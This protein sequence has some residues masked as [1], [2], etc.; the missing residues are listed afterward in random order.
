MKVLYYPLITRV[1]YEKLISKFSDEYKAFC[2]KNR[3]SYVSALGATALS[4]GL[5]YR[6]RFKLTT[7][8]ALTLGS[9]A[10]TKC[11]LSC[12]FNYRMKNNCDS[13]AKDVAKTYPE[14]KYLKVDYTDSNNL[15]KI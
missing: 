9:F 1:D 15:H 14:I 6:Y 4:W 5:A 7:F 8:V 12:Y 2:V 11:S 3:L 10:F 13:F